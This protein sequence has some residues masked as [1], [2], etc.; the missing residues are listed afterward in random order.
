M[1]NW[2]TAIAAALLAL[3]LTGAQAHAKPYKFFVPISEGL[4]MGSLSNMLKELAATAQTKTGIEIQVV[5]YTYEKGEDVMPRIVD[6]LKKKQIDFSFMF[7]QDFIKYAKSGETVA[8]P[9]F[10]ITMFGKPYANMCVY[11]R[12]D[13]N[14]KTAQ[15]LKGKVWGGTH[16]VATRYILYKNGI[17]QPMNKFF[18]KMV[19]INDS[20]TAAMLDALLE[21]KID[22][23]V[24]ASFQVGMVRANN[25]KYNAL[26][27]AQCV[28]Y[29]HNWVFVHHKDLPKDLVAKIKKTFLNAHKDKDFAKFHF[30]MKAIQGNFVDIEA[31]DL[32]TTKEIVELAEDK[33]WFAEEKAFI[34][35]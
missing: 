23:A 7:S 17:D 8:V 3:T 34:G 26:A 9:F 5:D 25:K 29:E 10:T 18:S 16:T 31:K 6:M 22:A 24:M 21:N 1:K 19:Q 20:N 12:K 30:L 28:E 14:L 32:K 11:T 13:D 33:G 35:K 2:K 4:S 27:E 15:S